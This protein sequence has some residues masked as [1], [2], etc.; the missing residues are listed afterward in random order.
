M[1]I[2]I[3]KKPDKDE[4]VFTVAFQISLLVHKQVLGYKCTE[5]D[6]YSRRFAW[7][8]LKFLQELLKNLQ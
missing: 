1:T 3:S 4:F 8:K 6:L 2:N 5:K 7:N